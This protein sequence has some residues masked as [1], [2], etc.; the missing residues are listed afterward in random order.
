MHMAEY[1]SVFELTIYSS[2]IIVMVGLSAVYYCEPF[3]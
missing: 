3:F 1:K 2:V